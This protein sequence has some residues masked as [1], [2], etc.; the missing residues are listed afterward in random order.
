MTYSE[1]DGLAVFEGCI[2]MGIADKVR[3]S[4][5]FVR[6]NPGVIKPGD[7]T[8]GIRISGVQYRWKNN[9]IAY[10]IDPSLPN[11][12]RVTDAIEHWEEHTPIRFFVRDPD[13]P[14]H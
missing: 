5:K 1:V 9:K 8:L 12:Q 13:N 3:A 14:A 7:Q 2:I 4:T 11:P 10:A 6:E